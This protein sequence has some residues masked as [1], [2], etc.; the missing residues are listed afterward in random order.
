MSRMMNFVSFHLCRTIANEGKNNKIRPNV[1]SFCEV[2]EIIRKCWS[3]KFH[4]WYWNWRPHGKAVIAM[5]TNIMSRV[6][7]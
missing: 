5:R 2:A 7:K 6:E 1:E 3:P 4:A